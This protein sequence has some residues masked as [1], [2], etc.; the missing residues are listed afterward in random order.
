MGRLVRPFQRLE[1]SRNRDT[2]GTGLGLSIA[3]DVARGEGGTL[4]LANRPQGGLRAEIVLPRAAEPGAGK[5]AS[6]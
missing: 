2:G 5:R 3:D 4:L 1:C 6:G